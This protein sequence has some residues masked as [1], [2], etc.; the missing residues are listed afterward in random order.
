MKTIILTLF[1]FVLHS[2]LYG[3]AYPDRHST[4]H[5]EVWISCQA[6][7]SPNPERGNSHWIQYDLGE[8]Y[9]LGTSTIWNANTPGQTDR[10]L[11]M[12]A[13]DYSMDGTTWTELGQYTLKRGP[14]SAFYEGDEGPDF[15]KVAARYVLITALSNYGG[16]CYSL[17]EVR[18]AAKPAETTLVN[19]EQLDITIAA[20][21][22]PAIDKVHVVLNEMP[23]GDTRYDFIDI[24]G[25]LIYSRKLA[26]KEFTLDVGHLNSGA[27]TLTVY[28]QKAALSTII[29]VVSK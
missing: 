17:A 2:T 13:V 14:G 20:S 21:P 29:N 8:N 26:Q 15:E 11:S 3:Q 4:S 25:K 28:N 22:N 5:T 9:E 7:E 23:E 1:V 6:K 10:G 18:I 16:D 12:I 27:Y 19:E 24:Q